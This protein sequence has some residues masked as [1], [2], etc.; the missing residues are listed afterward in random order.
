MMFSPAAAYR[1]TASSCV[2]LGS[3]VS[4]PL[5]RPLHLCRA[6][7]PGSVLWCQGLSLHSCCPRAVV[8]RGPV[9]QLLHGLAELFLEESHLHLVNNQLLFPQSQSLLTVLVQLLPV[10]G[11]AAQL[12]QPLLEGVGLWEAEGAVGDMQN[13]RR[14]QVEGLGHAY[15]LLALLLGLLELPQFQVELLHLFLIGCNLFLLLGF[16]LLGLGQLCL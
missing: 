14:C 5:A 3:A 2:G 7:G 16:L 1:A 10:L 13:E 6:C 12:L 15:L 11:L 9:L 4:H 8:L